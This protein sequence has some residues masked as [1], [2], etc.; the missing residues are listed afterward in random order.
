MNAPHRHA[1]TLRRL[2]VN[3][4]MVLALCTTMGARDAAANTPPTASFSAS[5]TT[6]DAPLEVMFKGQS[7]KDRDGRIV[8]Y[9]WDF[10]GGSGIGP[11]AKYTF[12]AP[13]TYLVTLT[14]TDDKGARDTSDPLTI[15]VR[16]AAAPSP[17]PGNTAPVI[18]GS[19]GSSVTASSSYRFQPSAS[20]ADGDSLTFSVQ[21]KPAWAS[22]DRATGQ[23]AGTP[24]SADVGRYSNITI[25]VSDGA[26]TSA[27]PA[28][29]IDVVDVA[30]GSVT[31][32][33]TPPT[34]NTDGSTLTNLAGY[35]I[36]YGQS[37]KNLSQVI[38]L[39]NPGLTS[40]VIESLASGTWYFAVKAV[41]AAG[42]ESDFSAVAS[43][44]V[45]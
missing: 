10:A 30:N 22:F 28:F 44:A 37:A 32:N 16:G 19:P 33:W 40:A 5:K 26:V 25:A 29:S 17:D 41:N 1:C 2:A 12:T 15:T 6:G 8:D 14:V 36:S 31:L 24:S 21:N 20:D 39:M 9:R 35:R 13:G 34:Q 27:L 23:L 42:V 38:S 11:V 43:K 3:A 45:P 4:V 7:S 18:S